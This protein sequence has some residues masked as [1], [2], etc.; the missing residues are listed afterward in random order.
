[1]IHS[2]PGHAEAEVHRDAMASNQRCHGRETRRSLGAS[3]VVAA[4]WAWPLSTIRPQVGQVPS[5]RTDGGDRN[6]SQV[7]HQGTTPVSPRDHTGGTPWWR[8]NSSRR[9]VRARAR[10][11]TARP[12]V[13]GL[14]DGV[15]DQLGREVHEVDVF[16]VLVAPF[17]DVR[18][19]FVGVLDGVDLVVEDRR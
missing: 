8:W 4:A 15:D 11:V 9:R 3:S 5:A 6:R 17:R 1:M 12:E 19:A 2:M 10:R 13:V 18:G 7:A 16:L 14:D